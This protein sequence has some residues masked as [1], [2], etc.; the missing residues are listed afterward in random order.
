MKEKIFRVEELTS[1]SIILDIITSDYH[2]AWTVHLTKR[3]VEKLI[4]ILADAREEM[5]YTKHQ[6][7]FLAEDLTIKAANR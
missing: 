5:K 6:K 2:N 7:P 4:C 3:E 1:K